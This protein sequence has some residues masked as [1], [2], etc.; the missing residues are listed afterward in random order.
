MANIKN[1]FIMNAKYEICKHNRELVHRSQ[2]NLRPFD[3]V[4]HEEMAQNE[5]YFEASGIKIICSM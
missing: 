1:K 4:L 5:I 3:I 2:Y